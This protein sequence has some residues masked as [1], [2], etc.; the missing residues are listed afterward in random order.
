MFSCVSWKI[1]ALTKSCYVEVFRIFIVFAVHRFHLTKTIVCIRQLFENK[2]NIFHGTYTNKHTAEHFYHTG[3]A[4]KVDCSVQTR[5]NRN[6]SK[7]IRWAGLY[8]TSMYFT[9]K[10]S[11]IMIIRFHRFCCVCVCCSDWNWFTHTNSIQTERRGERESE[12]K[13]NP[14]LCSRSNA[15][16]R[17]HNGTVNRFDYFIIWPVRSFP[18]TQ[19]YYK[20]IL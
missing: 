16:K 14:K 1:E 20:C 12:T 6:C 17:S 9:A 8:R 10:A 2:L 7:S 3:I 5:D 15:A 13:H 19:F 4:R 11:W 18:F